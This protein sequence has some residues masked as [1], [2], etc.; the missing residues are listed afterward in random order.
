VS[1]RPARGRL[2]T[3]FK[4]PEAILTICRRVQGPPHV[5]PVRSHVVQKSARNNDWTQRAIPLTMAE[6]IRFDDVGPDDKIRF[7]N[8]ALVHHPSAEPTG[9][10]IGTSGSHFS[11]GWECG[12]CDGAF[13]LDD[14]LVSDNLPQCPLCDAI[15]WDLVPP[16]R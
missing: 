10:W 6:A 15:G 16:C 13:R 1:H 7:I 5:Q 14:V 12:S 8:D 2:S 9:G 3:P 11:L 4:G